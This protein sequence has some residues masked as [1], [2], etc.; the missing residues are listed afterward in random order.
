ML[1]HIQGS[2]FGLATHG[3]N[4]SKRRK[5]PKQRII[6]H[7]F[8]GTLEEEP[9]NKDLQRSHRNHHQRLNNTEVENPALGTP[10]RTEVTVLTGTEV[11]L[12][13]GDGRKLS[14]ELV[15]GFLQAG[16]L[17]GAGALAGRQ[18]GALLVLDLRGISD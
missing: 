2:H 9:H 13:A 7:T 18:L 6:E 11:L 10:H 15:D 12:V 5:S 16:G 17:F 4:G 14:G 1:E 3:V 8:P